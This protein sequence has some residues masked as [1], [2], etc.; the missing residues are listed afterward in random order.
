M[1]QE[2]EFK[3]LKKYWTFDLLH[4]K[5][6]VSSITAN[7]ETLLKVYGFVSGKPDEKRTAFFPP[8]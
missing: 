5:N 4:D 6:S 8:F 7:T 3:G 2:H 1:S